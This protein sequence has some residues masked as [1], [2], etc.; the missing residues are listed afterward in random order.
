MNIP[1]PI[2]GEELKSLVFNPAIKR[3]TLIDGLLSEHSSIMLSAD[4][5]TGK[6]YLMLQALV[7]YASGYPVFGGFAVENPGRVYI[8]QKERAVN[9]VLERLET[10]SD[11]IKINWENIIIDTELQSLS[12]INHKVQDIVLS[13]IAK[14]KPSIVGI[15][16]IGAGLGGLSKDEIANEFCSFLT[17]IKNEVGNSDWLNHHTVKQGYHDGKPF[18]KE[19][20]FYGSQWLDA[21]VTGHYHVKKNDA[22]THWNN[23]KDTY[24]NLAKKFSL[25]FDPETGISYSDI[26]SMTATDKVRTFL[27]SRKA[28]ND[29]F[30]FKEL[31]QILGV[32]VRTLRHTLRK[33]VFE[34]SLTVSKSGYSETLYTVNF[35]KL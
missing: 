31:Q 3:K 23:T 27:V 10:F 15:D 34:G 14:F 21:Y 7:Q 26:D 16:P 29:P 1:D 11:K 6:S 9:E 24:S 20:P 28:K 13:R 4:P 18:E 2:S 17:R 32:Q 30:T 5:G 12:F 35:D 8:I 22:G 19:K 25:R 33:Y